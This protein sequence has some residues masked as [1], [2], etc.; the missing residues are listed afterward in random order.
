M[1]QVGIYKLKTHIAELIDRVLRGETIEIT[2]H[3]VPVAKLV[4]VARQRTRE[5]V[6][7]AIERLKEFRRTHSLGDLTVREMIEE[8]RE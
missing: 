5:E 4:P 2:R 3:G 6:R 7:A 8:G 1:E